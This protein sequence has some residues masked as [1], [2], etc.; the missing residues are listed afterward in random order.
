MSPADIDHGIVHEGFHPQ[1][2]T[3]DVYEEIDRILQ[4]GQMTSGEAITFLDELSTA[5]TEEAAEDAMHKEWWREHPDMP[6]HHDD[7]EHLTAA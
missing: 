5:P 1:F 7:D 3:A 6:R 2:H 4:E